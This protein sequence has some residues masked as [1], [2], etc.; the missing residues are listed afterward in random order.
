MTC[1]FGFEQ[2]EL[3][4]DDHHVPADADVPADDDGSGRKRARRKGTSR[5]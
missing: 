3:V 4:L 2:H 5:G 1:A